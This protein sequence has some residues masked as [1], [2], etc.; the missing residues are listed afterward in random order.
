MGEGTCKSRPSQRRDRR[1]RQQA[2]KNRNL[3]MGDGRRD[4]RRNAF[5]IGLGLG[6]HF[7]EA[8]RVSRDLTIELVGR[9]SL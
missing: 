5:L 9:W 7:D 8:K 3:R 4:L 6:G 1:L 2:G